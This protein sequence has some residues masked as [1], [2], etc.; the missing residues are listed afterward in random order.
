[1]V[2]GKEFCPVAGMAH[3]KWLGVNLRNH[4]ASFGGKQ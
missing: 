2:V 4:A 1:M 3:M